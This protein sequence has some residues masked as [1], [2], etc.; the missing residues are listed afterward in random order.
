METSKQKEKTSSQI[1][2]F[3]LLRRKPLI[4]RHIEALKVESAF[5]EISGASRTIQRKEAVANLARYLGLAP[6]EQEVD[7]FFHRVNGRCDLAAFGRFCSLLVHDEDKVVNFRELFL[8]YDQ[9]HTGKLK[10][11]VVKMIFCNLGEPLSAAEW[12]SFEGIFDLADKKDDDLVPYEPI[13]RKLL[14][15]PQ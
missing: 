8:V 12:R 9:E 14:D 13:V 2:S 1:C 4:I 3:A 15:L 5:C 7:T 6:S 10:K 11:R